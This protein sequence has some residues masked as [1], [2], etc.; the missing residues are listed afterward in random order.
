MEF[1]G[2]LVLKIP[3]GGHLTSVQLMVI[4]YMLMYA[5]LSELLYFMKG[6]SFKKKKNIFKVKEQKGKLKSTV[7]Y[8]PTGT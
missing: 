6:R 5:A 8:D 7:T 4:E 3:E 2:L 1:S